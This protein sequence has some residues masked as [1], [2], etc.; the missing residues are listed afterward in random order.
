MKVSID[1]ETRSAVDL[2][3]AGAHV[4]AA[5]PTT[6]VMCMGWSLEGLGGPFLWWHG[7]PFPPKLADAITS[8]A[9]IHAWNA[10]FERIM[11]TVMTR[12]H[13]AP[14]VAL[15][16]WRCTM[17]RALLQGFPAALD[18]AGPSMGLSVAKDKAG[19]QL[20]LR[21]SK[22]RRLIGPFDA[23]YKEAVQR[24]QED[25]LAGG[26]REFTT[27]GRPDGRVDVLQ[28]W[29]D[30]DRMTK[31]GLYCVQDVVVE[32]AAATFLDP[33]GE[34]ELDGWRLDQRINDRGFY[35][36][37]ELV[38]KAKQLV[39]P[40]I[41]AANRILAGITDRELRSVTKPNDIRAWLNARLDLELDSINKETLS[42]LLAE[43]PMLNGDHPRD[44]VAVQ[45]IRLRLA[46]AKTSTAKLNALIRGTGADGLFRGGLQYAGAGRTSRWAGRRFQPQNIPRPEWWALEAI[47]LVMNG[48]IPQIE[49]LLGNPLEAISSI[50][51]S[52]ITARPGHELSVADYNA[53]EARVAAWLA[54]AI[55]IL[56]AYATGQDPYRIMAATIFGYLDW[57]DVPKGGIERFLGKKL[58]L[59]AQYGLGKK[60]FWESCREDGL[61][62]E[63]DL[64]ARS[65]DAYRQDNHEIPAAWKALDAA[66][67]YAMQNPYTWA[68]CLGGKIH[69]F[70]DENYLR[71]RL[72]SGRCLSYLYP[73]LEPDVTPWGTETYKILFWGWNGMKNRMEWQSMWGGRW[74]ENACQA[75]SRDLMLDAAL[76]LDRDGWGIILSVHDE[77]LTDNPIGERDARALEA[78]MARPPAWAADLPL[79]VEGWTGH[80]YRK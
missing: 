71:M 51:R 40:A 43:H 48:N 36:D 11:W 28:W 32:E 44:S 46:A 37:M 33:M 55:K 6:E 77:L 52:C 17:V 62:I 30:E 65:I 3:Q 60:R 26:L 49:L 50:L 73:K 54:G 29:V 79:K 69:F 61:F 22:P 70:R 58:I 27:V 15:E 76:R 59:G 41:K 24:A 45:V 53:I 5:H 7:Q 42:L 38:H 23:Y 64:A 47:P 18:H 8:G 56:N 63:Q 16:Q 35:V 72:P 67:G 19:H 31:L 13:G 74:M 57:R 75:I 4:Y 34:G 68:P 25:E 39:E 9:E 66:A 1:F 78:E 21:V 80:R 2:T 20:M 14:P 12:D 10:A